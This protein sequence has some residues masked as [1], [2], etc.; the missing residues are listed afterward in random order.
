MLLM[1]KV[2]WYMPKWLDRIVPHLSIEGAEY[3]AERDQQTAAPEPDEMTV[4]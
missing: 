1:G 3:F 2:N 4:A